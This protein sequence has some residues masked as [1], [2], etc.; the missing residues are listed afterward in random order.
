MTG[1]TP[2][3]SGVAACLLDGLGNRAAAEA[4]RMSE[5]TVA[6]HVRRMRQR[7]H[8]NSRVSLAL[9]LRRHAEPLSSPQHTEAA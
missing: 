3:E 4:L 9:E 8:A 2:A 5:W 6:K 7:F 1:F